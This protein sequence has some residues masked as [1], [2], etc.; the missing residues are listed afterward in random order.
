[1]THPLPSP[2]FSPSPKN[3]G[4]K[5]KF[6]DPPP[7]PTSCCS[8]SKGKGRMR[9]ANFRSAN[10]YAYAFLVRMGFY[11]VSRP[12]SKFTQRKDNK[13]I[14]NRDGIRRKGYVNLISLYPCHTQKQYLKNENRKG[15]NPT[16]WQGQFTLSDLSLVLIRVTAQTSHASTTILLMTPSSFTVHGTYPQT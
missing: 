16:C 2:R 11:R 9:A 5:A 3:R 1:M 12:L 10:P 7:Q 8:Q 6:G 13:V 4:K 15:G 14:A